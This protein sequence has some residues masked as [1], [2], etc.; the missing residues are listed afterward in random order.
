M[1]IY[2][3]NNR[4]LNVWNKQSQVKEKT[5]NSTITV[6]NLIPVSQQ[7]VELAKK[8]VKTEY[9]NVIISHLYVIDIYRTTNNC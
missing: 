4:P 3:P 2:E 9:L 5:D 1:H 8:L 6:R 7:L